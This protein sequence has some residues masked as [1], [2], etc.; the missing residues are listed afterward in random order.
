NVAE[1][2]D[3]LVVDAEAPRL[4]AQPP[5]V[6]DRVAEMREFPVEHRN[7][8]VG[9]DDEVAEAVVAVPELRRAARRGRVRLE[10]SQPELECGMRLAEQVERAEVL[11]DLRPRLHPRHAGDPPPADA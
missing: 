4:H 11:A 2:A 8:A 5:E 3:E 9:T 6:F 1:P 7:D 10:P